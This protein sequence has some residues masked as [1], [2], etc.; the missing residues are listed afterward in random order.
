[1][2]LQW[3]LHTILHQLG[4]CQSADSKPAGSWSPQPTRRRI[5]DVCRFVVL[6]AFSL[7]IGNGRV[8]IRSRRLQHEYTGGVH[9]LPLHQFRPGLS[10]GQHGL[11][12]GYLG[13][14]DA[15]RPPHR[16]KRIR[17]GC[18]SVRFVPSSASPRCPSDVELSLGI[19]PTRVQCHPTI[20]AGARMVDWRELS[21]K[22]PYALHPTRHKVMLF[23]FYHSACW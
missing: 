15:K 20:A 21:G 22:H 1:M 9:H 16:A 5:M 18:G 13:A 3:N 6:S 11:Y 4:A 19:G 8:R 7:N 12:N 10:D 23:H 14:P 2:L 17:S